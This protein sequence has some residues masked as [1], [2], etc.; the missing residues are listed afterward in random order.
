MNFFSFKIK[1]SQTYTSDD[2]QNSEKDIE[3]TWN[4]EATFI[5]KF[6]HRG[7]NRAKK[8]DLRVSGL[9]SSGDRLVTKNCF[10]INS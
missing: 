3:G 1:F 7:S 10:G 9:R 8:R 2:I 6:W 5:S 4:F